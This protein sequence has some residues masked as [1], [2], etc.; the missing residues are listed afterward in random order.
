MGRSRGGL[1][2]K[3]HAVVDGRGL[4]VRLGLTPGQ[5]HDT[6]LAADLLGDLASDT[7]VIAVVSTPLSGVLGMLIAYLVL[8][9]L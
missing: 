3:I 9:Y 7:V 1:T 4:P 6:A 5:A 8:Y 2:T